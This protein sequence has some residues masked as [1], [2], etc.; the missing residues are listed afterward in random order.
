MLP[1]GGVYIAGK[2]RGEAD[3]GFPKFFEAES[4]LLA[5]TEFFPV[6]NPARRDIEKTGAEFRGAME[7]EGLELEEAMQADLDF[8]WS[9]DC[10]CVVV[11]DGWAGS[12]G[13]YKEIE[14]A[15]LLQK[16]V[17]FLRRN[18]NQLLLWPDAD[19]PDWNWYVNLDRI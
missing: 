7:V 17:F 11:L 10:A 15:Q 19:E 4:W 1:K 9:D 5:N 14:L 12:E 6:F 16:P 3:C 18:G 13:T 8:I 2:M